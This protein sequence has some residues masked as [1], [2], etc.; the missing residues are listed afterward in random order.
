MRRTQLAALRA[1][2]VIE[3][4]LPGT[5]R[6]AAV[7]R[8]DETRLR[9]ALRW[10]GPDSAADGRSAG[11]WYGLEGVR[12]AD[13]EVVVRDTSH[14]RALGVRT[15]RVG[16]FGSLMIRTHR[17]LRVTG[18][19]AT[20]VRL[21]R[22]LSGEALEVAFE[23]ARRHK[24]TSVPAVHSYLD[25]YGRRGQHG[26]AAVRALLEELDPLHPSRSRL[27][28]KTRRLLVAHGVH[29][30]EREFPLGG[31]YFDF[32][33]RRERTILETNGRK[34]HGDPVDFE[35]DN[36]KWSVPGRHGFKLVLATWDKVTR[37]SDAFVDELTTTLAA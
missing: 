24:L 3:R 25:R 23:D 30:F 7:P 8:S 12:A 36:E 33:F 35:H 18:P 26:L 20:I 9:A 11:W 21:A 19:E 32:A 37:T 5:Y 31:Y 27:E 16:E 1:L 13:P 17:G 28:V 10:A 22:A 34:W 4:E 29:G 15:R 6:L 2:G 14:P